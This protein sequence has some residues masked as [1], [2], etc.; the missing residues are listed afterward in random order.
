MACYSG[1][2]SSKMENNT[3]YNPNTSG[4]ACGEG[5]YNAAG[6]N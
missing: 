2:G 3:S 6:N 1:P 5:C 4:G